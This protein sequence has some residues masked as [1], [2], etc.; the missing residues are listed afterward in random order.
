MWLPV[1]VP[2]DAVALAFDFK[3]SGEGAEDR[4]VAGVNDTN[5]FSLAARFIADDR[6]MSSGPL[7]VEAWAG[8]DVEL[9]F[10]LAG[11]TSTDA[12]LTIEG[13]RFLSLP[14]PVLRTRSLDAGIVLEWTEASPGFVLEWTAGL[15][16]AP[17]WTPITDVSGYAGQRTFT[18]QVPAQ[19]GFYRLRRP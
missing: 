3:L 14:V 19:Q 15:T 1:H 12:R 9:F 6:P 8:Q 16:P 10:G 5:V 2:A 11:G 17:V 4:V 13:I 7:P 18:N